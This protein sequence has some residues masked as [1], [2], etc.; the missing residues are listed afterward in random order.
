MALLENYSSLNDKLCGCLNY[1]LY[2]KWTEEYRT[3]PG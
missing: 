1:L 2:P 3:E